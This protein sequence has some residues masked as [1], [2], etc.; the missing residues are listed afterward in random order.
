MA[1]F[2]HRS[3]YGFDR[4]YAFPIQFRGPTENGCIAFFLS[5]ANRV[6]PSQRSGMNDLGSAKL[7]LLRFAAQFDTETAVCDA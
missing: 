4:T 7:E 1:L 5:D 3:H 2:T 6:S